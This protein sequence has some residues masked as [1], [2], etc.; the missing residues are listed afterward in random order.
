MKGRSLPVRNPRRR[1]SA[2]TRAGVDSG[3]NG[4]GSMTTVLLAES[5]G[6]ASPGL[7]RIR[8]LDHLVVATED[9]FSLARAG[10]LPAAPRIGQGGA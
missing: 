3:V 2:S 8:V 7:L 9:W 4:D 6:P 10:D 1:G 5:A